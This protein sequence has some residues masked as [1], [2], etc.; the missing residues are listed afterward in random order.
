VS[1]VGSFTWGDDTP[2][3]VFSGLL[4]NNIKYIAEAVS[5]EAGHTLGLQHQSNY[6]AECTKTSEYGQGQGTGEISWAPIMGSRF[7]IETLRPGTMDPMRLD[8]A[9]CKTILKSLREV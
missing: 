8:A 4:N 5:H 6:D 1:Y 9:T 7:I 2:G 3:W